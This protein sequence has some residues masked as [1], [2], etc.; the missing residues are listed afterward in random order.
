MI[1][2]MQDDDREHLYTPMTD[3]AKERYKTLPEQVTLQ[4]AMELW[5]LGRTRTLELLHDFVHRGLLQ[6]VSRGVYTRIGGVRAGDVQA[7]PVRWDERELTLGAAEGGEWPKTP[8]RLAEELGF[9]NLSAARP[10][11]RA[12]IRR[13]LLFPCNVREDEALYCKEPPLRRPVLS[14]SAQEALDKIGLDEVI[15]WKDLRDRLGSRFGELS[16]ELMAGRYLYRVGYGNYTRDL[17]NPMPLREVP[18]TPLTELARERLATVEW[19]TTLARAS[20]AWGLATPTAQSFMNSLI[21]RGE[22]IRVEDNHY[23]R[24][25]YV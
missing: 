19:P 17:E 20:K 2:S 21:R 12:L 18:E 15:T 8:A 1:P 13:S 16:H 4:S 3:L 10:T 9:P 25:D 14:R 24:V 23:D 5:G 7:V 6:K 11:L 22:V